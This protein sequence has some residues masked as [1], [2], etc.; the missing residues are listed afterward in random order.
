MAVFLLLVGSPLA[1]GCGS[2][3]RRAPTST[4]VRHVNVPFSHPSGDRPQ[5]DGRKVRSRW[6]GTFTFRRAPYG[7]PGAAPARGPGACPGWL[8]EAGAGGLRRPAQSSGRC[9]RGGDP[10]SAE[11]LRDRAPGCGRAADRRRH[12]RP[13]PPEVNR[14]GGRS[15]PLGSWIRGSVNGVVAT[16]NPRTSTIPGPRSGGW[17]IRT[18]EGLHPT[19]FPSV[20]HRPL[21]ES[22]RCHASAVK[23]RACAT[24]EQYIGR[25]PP[26]PARG[27]G[28]CHAVRRASDG[29]PAAR[30]AP[31]RD[32]SSSA[33]RSVEFRTEIGPVPHRDRSGSAPRSVRSTRSSGAARP[34]APARSFRAGVQ[35]RAV[36]TLIEVPEAPGAAA[37]LADVLSG[38][39]VARLASVLVRVLAASMSARMTLTARI[40]ETRAGNRVIARISPT[41]AAP[42]VSNV[43]LTD[44]RSRESV[45]RAPSCSAGDRAGETPAPTTPLHAVPRREGAPVP[46][47][48]GS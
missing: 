5:K 3:G 10:S 20:R 22:S 46:V 2:G 4:E 13:A 18:P 23:S 15:S 40:S 45:S 39:A 24:R 12:R 8:P 9:R 6:E 44:I 14:P 16:K 7:R 27:G 30:F 28:I 19:R 37:P 26:R 1:G 17:G 29:S 41:R 11:E 42:R 21:G 43:I 35:R 36:L 34:S 31:R 33:P 47:C 25:P 48:P 38:P 32:R